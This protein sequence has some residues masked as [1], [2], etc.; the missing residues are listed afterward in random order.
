MSI[1]SNYTTPDAEL[2][3]KRQRRVATATSLVISVLVVILVGVLLALVLLP[4]LRLNS[5]LIVA[6]SAERLDE[7]V[8][9]RPEI[10]PQ[11]Q[12]KPS[13]PSSSMSKVIATMTPSP[14][15]VPVPEVD[16]PDPSLDFG[17][18]D[19]FGEGWGSGNGFGSG[20]GGTTFFGQSVKAE[21]IAYVIDY[22][23]SMRGQGR[24]E[25][26]R[27]EL[28][29]SV[30]KI[31]MKTNYALLFFA[32]PA[33]VAGDD[34]DWNKQGAIVSGKGGRKFNWKSKGKANDWE[35]SGKKEP[36]DWLVATKG[37]VSKS[38][39]IIQSTRLVWGTRWDNPLEMALN[40]DPPPQVIY[41]MTDGAASGSD[42]WARSVGA[43]AK[44]RGIKINCIAMMEPKAH[45]DMDDL[46]KRTGGQFTI[47]LKGG[48]RK[49]VR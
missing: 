13:A 12:R 24:E 18:G 6:Y 16:V 20:N 34:V 5:D 2:A 27:K 8:V 15:A 14:T 25:L 43:K 37:Q 22:S 23:A 32:G 33:W 38:R 17:D 49:K 1:V 29:D 3:L 42:K 7:E 41:F 4:V 19:D 30:M 21:R 36:V 28:T 31:A 11:V 39:K 10:T 35:H 46:A 48:K 26:M 47:V 44:S 9:D 45:K 40:M